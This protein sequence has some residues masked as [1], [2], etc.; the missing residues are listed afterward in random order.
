MDTN[1]ISES[2][3]AGEGKGLILCAL[4]STGLSLSVSLLEMYPE[5]VYDTLTVT[6]MVPCRDH[7]CTTL[8]GNGTGA[9]RSSVFL[10]MSILK[11][12]LSNFQFTAWL[13]RPLDF[14]QRLKRHW[15][16]NPTSL[17]TLFLGSE[18]IGHH[19]RILGVPSVSLEH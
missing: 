11:A 19:Q 17:K 6:Q 12:F 18:T 15:P 3:V 13:L 8:L 1:S 4:T 10:T 7:E 2:Q 16:R 9:T 14:C 5:R